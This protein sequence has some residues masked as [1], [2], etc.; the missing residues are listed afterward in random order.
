MF[1]VFSCCDSSSAKLQIPRGLPGLRQSMREKVRDCNSH[2]DYVLGGGIKRNGRDGVFQGA[3]AC[4][5][6]AFAD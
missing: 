4:S 1:K 5:D 3:Q 2:N 6:A